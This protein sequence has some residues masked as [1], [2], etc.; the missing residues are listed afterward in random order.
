MDRNRLLKEN[1]STAVCCVVL[2]L[3][4]IFPVGLNS[5]NQPDVSNYSVFLKGRLSLFPFAAFCFAASIW[6][7]RRVLMEY[8]ILC[9]CIVVKFVLYRELD[10]GFFYFIGFLCA[11]DFITKNP[12]NYRIVD[13][14]MILSAIVFTLQIAI[15]TYINYRLGMRFTITSSIGDRNYTAYFLLNLV[16]FFLYTGKKKSSF[17]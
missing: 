2:V 17:F 4:Y 7:N 6:M 10:F 5:V 11:F 12:P 8:L 16:M 3:I 1:I 15:C 13:K 14:V 9:A